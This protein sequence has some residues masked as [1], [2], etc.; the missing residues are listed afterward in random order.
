MKMAK[1]GTILLRTL[2]KEAEADIIWAVF[3][4]V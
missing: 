4:T 2:Q 1:N 3:A